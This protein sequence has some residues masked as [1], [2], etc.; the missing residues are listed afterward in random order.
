MSSLIK[1]GLVVRK[2]LSTLSIRLGLFAMLMIHVGPL[3]SALQLA[4]AAARSSE[5]HQHA[6]HGDASSAHAHHRPAS[7]SAPDWLAALELCGYCELLTLSPPLTLSLKLILPRHEPERFLALPAAP[8][9]P[10]WRRSA[11]YARAPPATFHC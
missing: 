5:H 4:Q 3:Y 9:L 8:L 6:G 2:R 1:D 11:G 10:I 7:G